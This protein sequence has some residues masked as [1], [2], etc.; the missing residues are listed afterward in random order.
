MVVPNN[1]FFIKQAIRTKHNNC[2]GW[3]FFKILF[4]LRIVDFH[5]IIEI[6]IAMKSKFSEIE[7]D[8]FYLSELRI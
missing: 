5:Y 6:N 4:Y 1:L 2:V 8:I 3:I 7:I